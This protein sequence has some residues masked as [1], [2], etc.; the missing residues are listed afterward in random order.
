M[1]EDAELGC[2]KAVP[3]VSLR[4]DELRCTSPGQLRFCSSPWFRCDE[5]Y[6]GEEGNLVPAFASVFGLR[7]KAERGA[8]WQHGGTCLASPHGGMGGVLACRTLS[9]VLRWV[10]LF[11][12]LAQGRKA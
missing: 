1:V 3:Q 11:G 2:R 5:K 9:S 7:G 4:L 6:S 10:G 8:V 12:S